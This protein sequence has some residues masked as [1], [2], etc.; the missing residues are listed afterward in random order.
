[1]FNRLFT[2]TNL[3]IV[4]VVIAGAA[5]FIFIFTPIGVSE[6]PAAKVTTIYFA[7][8]ISAAHQKI[9]DRFNATYR[10]RLEVVPVNLPFTKFSTNERKQLLTRA[11]RSK[12]TRLDI[13]AV[14][15][16]WV[17]RFVKWAEPLAQYFS[18]A[19][20]E[21]FLPQALASGVFENKLVGVP[22]Y[23]DIGV[24]YYRQD[25]LRTLPDYQS[26]TQKLNSSMV[27]EDFIQL[28]S[29][30][31]P[32]GQAFYLFPADSY[33]GL[34]CCF[35][36]NVSSQNT[37]V[38][39]GDSLRVN[40]PQARRALQLLVDLVTKYRLTPPAVVSYKEND[41]YRHALEHDAM[42]FRGWPGNLFDY[43]RQYP[44][45]IRQTAIAALPHFAGAKP[46][47]T[48]GGWNLMIA[49]DSDKKAAAVQFL[50]FATSLEMQQLIYAEM[51]FLPAIK[52]AYADTA[53]YNRHADLQYFRR[54]L[55]TGVHRPAL[56]EYTKIS[57]ILS[58]Y[59]NRAIRNEISV[60]AALQNAEAMI[61]SQKVMIN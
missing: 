40:T 52:A 45:K 29:R 15:L 57:D 58:F 10:G 21:N 14:D 59:A 37:P 13:F 47:A 38:L 6:P 11:L 42:F 35:I 16:V 31:T 44:D 3:L 32:S 48:V 9:I 30:L 22:L 26:L 34:I 36:E 51:G 53:F 8:N 25:L 41:V 55:E 46:A 61:R 28:G 50:K 12:S 23:V 24:M 43:R 17:P 18:P 7:D 19:E 5:L 33:E 2:G 20:Q 1:M 49:K 60:E 39:Q 27:W 56:V 54:L 4:S